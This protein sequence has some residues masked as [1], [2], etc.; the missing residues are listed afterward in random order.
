MVPDIKIF[1]K[2]FPVLICRTYAFT[3]HVSIGIDR[4][5][6]I[7][8]VAKAVSFVGETRLTSPGGVVSTVKVLP[9]LVRLSALSR[10]CPV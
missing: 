4:L 10:A 3:P 2:L 1:V 8:P 6:C 7:F 5:I 9:V